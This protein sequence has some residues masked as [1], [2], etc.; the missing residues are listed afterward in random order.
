MEEG[1]RF[2]GEGVG[3]PGCVDRHP[4]PGGPAATHLAAL[5]DVAGE[6]QYLQLGRGAADD[7]AQGGEALGWVVEGWR[8]RRDVIWGRRG[9][10]GWWAALSLVVWA[11]L[12]GSDKF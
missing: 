8:G 12:Q 5:E 3:A 1:Y 4:F 9:D 10:G 7:L 11:H 2:M 6:Q